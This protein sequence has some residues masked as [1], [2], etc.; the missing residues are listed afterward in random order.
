MSFLLP[1]S[2]P[3]PFVQFFFS[4]YLPMG[5]PSGFSSRSLC[6]NLRDFRV[7]LYARCHQES[8]DLNIRFLEN[9]N[10]ENKQT[11]Y[12]W[13][14]LLNVILISFNPW[15]FVPPCSFGLDSGLNAVWK[16]TSWICIKLKHDTHLCRAQ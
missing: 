11:F 8:S 7:A 9:M 16:M 5:L 14:L 3:F 6:S 2:F 13:L 10:L 12:P 15:L 4:L 1:V